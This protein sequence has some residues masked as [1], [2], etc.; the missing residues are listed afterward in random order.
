MNRIGAQFNLAFQ[1]LRQAPGFVFSVVT[2]MAFTLAIVFI[3]VSLV[4]TYFIRPLNVHDEQ[5]LYVIEQRVTTD[6]DVYDG[7]Q[8][9]K[10]II[11]WMRT[12]Q[13]LDDAAVIS[14][15]DIMITSLP[16]EPRA[17]ATFAS[18][19]YYKLFKVPLVLGQGFDSKLAFD[20][21]SHNVLIS[22]QM[23]I[24]YFDRSDQV[25]GKTL[26]TQNGNTYTITG[27]VS[28]DFEPPYMFY[29]GKTDIWLH[30]SENPRTFNE[31]DNQWNSTYRSLKI[32]GTAKPE[33]TQRDILA[34]FDKSIKSIK[35]EWLAGYPNVTDIAPI[36]TPFRT[37]ELGDKG[38]LSL[39]LLAGTLGLLLIAIL[40]VSNLLLSRALAQHRNLALQAVLGAKR[41]TLFISI[42]AQT[43]LLM[44][45]S[46]ASALFM[47]AWGIRGFK[48]LTLGKLPLVSS[49]SIDYK[50][51]TVAF[52]ICALLAYLF[53]L[54]SAS[55]VNFGELRKQLQMS[56]KNNGQTLSASKTRLLVGSQVG[57]ATALILVTAFSLSKTHETLNRPLGNDVKNRFT[58]SLFI[59]NEETLLSAT[60]SAKKRERLKQYLLALPQIKT[61]SLGRS[62]VR[63]TTNSST[64]T[65][66]QGVESIF[67]PQARVGADYFE[68][69]GMNIL[70]GRTFSDAAMREDTYEA[71]V[72]HSMAKLL[73]PDGDVIG[74]TYTGLNQQYTIVGV[75][76]DFNHPN[77]FYKDLGRH[78]WW[79]FGPYG[80][81]FIVEFEEG[82]SLDRE[83]LLDLLRKHDKRFMI[84]EYM[85]LEQELKHMRHIDNITLYA[86]YL[87]AAFTLMLAC[88]GIFGVLSYNLNTRRFE[89]GLRMAL[90]A[91][92]GHLYRLLAR[93]VLVPITIGASLATTLTLSILSYYQEQLTLWL[94]YSPLF[95]IP[96][97][98]LTLLCAALS[99]YWP[100]H[101]VLKHKP[102]HALRNE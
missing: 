97:V 2:T 1:S 52:I 84:W 37:V 53:A 59:P 102:M 83:N 41:R 96:A 45:A 87:L 40:N 65:N 29:N 78:I 70:A 20:A 63:R 49:V 4:N 31:R 79:A 18:P 66:A 13:S 9:Y 5:N 7:Y 69:E 27:V 94:S 85:S 64:M 91:K 60:E 23:W 77:S 26:V 6:T 3:V 11:H 17:I 81:I 12:Q 93:D 21:T 73:E 71:L 58:S 19:D 8:S 39:F 80:Y 42:L 16:G 75:T 44:M 86:S 101:K 55:L 89:F 54:I 56:G 67:V 50:V 100:M 48:Q 22:E 47:A 35:E 30:F 38:H 14:P 34:D 24:R 76:E 88:V 68:Q 36:V 28:A 74:K 57:L 95:A 15:A 46:M 43:F 82:A 98:L 10:G 62:P 33:L 92:A 99:G 61:V 51:V 32:V 72:S 25:L 90:G